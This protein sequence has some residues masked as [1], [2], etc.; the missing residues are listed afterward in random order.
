[1]TK[2]QTLT[3]QSKCLQWARERAK[4][5][6]S[7]LAQKLKVK[8]DKITT[9]EQSG[10]ISMSLAEK[11]AKAT[12][13]PLGYLFLPEPL[14][15][16]LPITD[17]RTVNTQ[18]ISHPTPDLLDV[19][20]DALSRQDWYREYILSNGG[21]ALSF[22]GSLRIVKGSHNIID[23]AKRIRDVVEWGAK[24]R[25]HSSSSEDV[26]SRH[27]DAVEQ[28]GI[29]V[30][31]SSIVGNNTSRHLSVSEFRGFA[32][33]D[34]YAPLIFINGQDAKAAQMFTL[35]HELVH[36]WLG[37]SGVSNLNQTYPS[38]ISTEYFC[39]QV[40]AELLVPLEELKTIWPM[41]ETSRDRVAQTSRYFRVSS[42]VI[43]RRLRDAGVLDREEFERR[44]TDE[45]VQFKL[46]TSAG[47]GDFYHALYARL[48]K[49]FVSALVEST[50]E[51]GTPYREAFQLL[52][53]NKAET[54][55]ELASRMRATA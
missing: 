1:M 34:R 52:G 21:D 40:A 49:R 30:M 14:T 39:N 32:L 38:E 10:E 35:A 37:V 7:E 5:G 55:R 29:L 45:L 53:V 18:D 47:G 43:L 33:S 25:E 20:D 42:L 17:F 27:I 46:K 15:E 13:T 51:G 28:V 22:V 31:R 9:W 44:Y 19:V 8:E 11:L 41:T 12:R 2:V 54:V 24:L 50:L 36:I 23:A 48:G 3:L 6:V 4:L 26:L 16:T